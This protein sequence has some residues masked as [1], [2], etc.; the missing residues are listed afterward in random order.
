MKNPTVQTPPITD[1]NPIKMLLT[2]DGT[3]NPEWK[4]IEQNEPIQDNLQILHS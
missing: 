2:E 1:P 3:Q 4:L